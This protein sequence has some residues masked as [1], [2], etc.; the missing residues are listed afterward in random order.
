[1]RE[2][3]CDRESL[4]VRFRVRARLRV[5][6]DR[7]RIRKLCRAIIAIEGV[8]EPSSLA[9]AVVDDDE[10]ARL[11]RAHRQ[12]D[13]PTDVLSFPLDVP[14]TVGN[15]HGLTPAFATP[16]GHP[17]EIGDIVI[18]YPRVIAQAAEFGHSI[19]R[20]LAYLVAH[21]LLHILGYDHENDLERRTMRA[22]EE[23]ALA[24]SGFTR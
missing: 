10:I 4:D 20:E 11:N 15:H 13:Q 5:R 12:I 22:R 14:L 18:S 23:T 1:M 21:G 17:R 3:D 24:S 16:P 2:V 7:R 9:V 19:E 6:I 8:T